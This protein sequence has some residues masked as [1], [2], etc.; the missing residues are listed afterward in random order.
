MFKLPTWA[1]IATIGGLVVA[2]A[3]FGY[4]VY[5]DNRTP[6]PVHVAQTNGQKADV[7]V[8]DKV[9]GDKVAGDKVQ[10]DKFVGDKIQGNKTSIDQRTTGDNSPA[11]SSGRDTFY[12]EKK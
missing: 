7:V 5:S 3:A 10:G 1:N 6:S 2:V 8:G 4:Q 12:K 11:I 9:A